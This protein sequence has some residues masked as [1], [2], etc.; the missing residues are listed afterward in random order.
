M[1][2][3]KRILKIIMIVELNYYE[4]NDDK[5]EKI[6]M[7]RGNSTFKQQKTFSVFA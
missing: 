6:S 4:S 7:R 5:E 3:K 1:N 2:R